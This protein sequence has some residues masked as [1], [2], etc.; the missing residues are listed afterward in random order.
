MSFCGDDRNSKFKYG[1]VLDE[2]EHPNGIQKYSSKTGLMLNQVDVY[3]N[4][5]FA[6]GDTVYIVFITYTTGDT[7][8]R[9][10]N[11]HYAIPLVTGNKED[12]S[13]LAKH[14]REHIDY[15]NKSRYSIR[16]NKI[17]PIEYTGPGYP[18]WAGYFEGDQNVSVYA[19]TMS[20]QDGSYSDHDLD[21]HDRTR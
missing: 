13:T 6:L 18:S 12:A 4:E 5:E 10:P 11:I 14:C 20:K 2:S 3:A 21:F 19:V 16:K 15:E 1:L 9:D 17:K 7:F 8:G